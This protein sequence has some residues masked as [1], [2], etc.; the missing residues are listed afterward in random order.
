M[1]KKLKPNTGCPACE[2]ILNKRE[3]HKQCK[4]CN[5]LY[6]GNKCENVLCMENK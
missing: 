5:H 6:V 2:L 4:S 1:Q 3:K